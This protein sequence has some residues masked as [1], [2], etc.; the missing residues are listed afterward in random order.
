VRILH[1]TAGTGGWHCGTCI[2]DDALVAALRALG[3]EADLVPLYLPIVADGEGCS[4]GE[5][6]LIGGV[7]AYLQQ[8]SG[9]F[10]ALPR[11]ADAPLSSRSM[12]GLAS[13]FA[14]STRPESLGAMTV[15]MLRGLQGNQRKEI[16]RMLDALA[17]RP[18]PDVVVLSNSLLVGLAAPLRDRLGAP[19]VCTVQGEP[20]FLDALDEGR[21]EAWA[22]V[23]EGLAG[24]DARVAVSG[25]AADLMSRRT[26]LP[27]GPFDVVHN[28]V[29]DEGWLEPSPSE[30]PAIGFLAR[31]IPLKGLDLV[32]DAF[33]TL[34]GEGRDV[35]LRLGGTLNPGDRPHVDA[36]RRRLAPWLADGTVELHPNLSPE[37]KRAFLSELAVLCVPALKDETFG[38][39][40]LE[41]M[42]AGVPVVAFARGAVTEVVQAA[43]G[44]VLVPPGDV[45][46]LLDALRALLDAPARR[47]ALGDAGRRGVLAGFTSRAMAE[48]EAAVLARVIGARESG[49][50]A[51]R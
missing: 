45:G 3:H 26:G 33:E 23:T 19:V 20:H 29:A 32:V 9:L 16:L 49:T 39:Y 12:L 2:R 51:S 1:L 22:L 44:G 13:R 35:R 8:A 30:P 43:G 10:R 47:R 48:R 46:A 27:R 38:L 7:N 17:T 50:A 28:G 40:L 34:R 31:M 42:R 18:R 37:G 6:V 4:A 21:E 5:P 25:F 14:G 36:L 41:A 24:C 15:S 11:W